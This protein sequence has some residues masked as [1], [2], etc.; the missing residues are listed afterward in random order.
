MTHSTQ[1][2][3]CAHEIR[4]PQKQAKKKSTHTLPQKKK[5]KVM[6]KSNNADIDL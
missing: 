1:P 2:L 6:K 5:N 3:F 4:D